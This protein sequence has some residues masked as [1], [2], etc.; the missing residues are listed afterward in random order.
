M[1]GGL[2]LDLHLHSTYSPDS[3]LPLPTAVEQLGAQGL[4]GFALTD[5]NTVAGHAALQALS[6]RYPQ[7]R[8][9]PGIEVSTKEG[10]LLALGLAEVPPLHR[11]VAETVEWVEAHGGVAVPAH[12]ARHAHGIGRRLAERLRV[13]ALETLNGHNS[14]VANA[15]AT[16]IAAQRS[17]GETGG[18]DA[19]DARGVGRGYTVFPDGVDRVADLLEELRQRRTRAEGVSLRYGEMARLAVR[20]VAQRAFRGF[21]SI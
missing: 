13:P 19:H 14:Q 20:T 6:E 8:F 15:R 5:H 3:R 10:H 2:R 21:R 9:I 12:P 1:T 4:H 11:P 7:Y 17:L 18:S 16:L